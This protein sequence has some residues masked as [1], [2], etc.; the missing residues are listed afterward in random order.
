MP[1]FNLYSFSILNDS[2]F[3][4]TSKNRGNFN[5]KSL[6]SIMPHAKKTFMQI[7]KSL[8][9]PLTWFTRNGWGKEISIP[10]C[11]SWKVKKNNLTC[12]LMVKIPS[13]P[14][15]QYK[16][17][18]EM[19]QYIWNWGKTKNANKKWERKKTFFLLI[20]IWLMEG[21][22]QV[23]IMQH[24]EGKIRKKIYLLEWK[25]PITFIHFS[26]IYSEICFGMFMFNVEENPAHQIE[27]KKKV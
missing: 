27:K 6:I 12:E 16:S 2:Q 17:S 9:L 13:L 25:L 3:A 20:L 15:I 7:P 11:T 1:K 10:G 24:E 18:R 14:S 19:N 4:F 8:L 5:Q 22:L 23:Q 26:K 21:K